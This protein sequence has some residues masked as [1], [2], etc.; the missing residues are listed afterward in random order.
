MPS[1]DP[2]RR[3]RTRS[4][5]PGAFVRDVRAA[6]IEQSRLRALAP[7]IRSQRRVSLARAR[8]QSGRRR[9]REHA[10]SIR[11]SRL[12]GDDVTLALLEAR[13]EQGWWI[14]ST[15]LSETFGIDAFHAQHGA[16]AL[17]LF[18]VDEQN[19]VHV[20]SEARALEARAGC[21]LT[22][23]VPPRADNDALA[24]AA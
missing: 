21:S 7:R 19:R 5:W 14:K 13:L 20:V 8:T 24:V 17:P 11:A 23:L 12:F 3:T 22:A 9:C 6:R 15:R 2:A 18:S 1:V 16:D 10:R 4:R